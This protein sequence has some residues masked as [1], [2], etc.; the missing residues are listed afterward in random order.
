MEIESFKV[1]V[2]ILCVAASLTCTALLL[3]AYAQNRVRL[4]LWSGMCFIGL[5]INNVILFLDVVVFP[6]NDLY[7]FRMIA[8]II[9]LLCL[10][11]GFIWEAE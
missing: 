5:T 10:L 9:G 6:E 7:V 8:T 2:Y 1:I 3:R 4:L 11:Y